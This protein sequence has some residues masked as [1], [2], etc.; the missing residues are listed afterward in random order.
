M[1]SDKVDYQMSDSKLSIISIMLLQKFSKL[2][3]GNSKFGNV[4]K[5]E[6]F[7]LSEQILFHS[8]AVQLM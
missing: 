8:H 3:K 4:N 6:R 5:S 7:E 2:I 1:K